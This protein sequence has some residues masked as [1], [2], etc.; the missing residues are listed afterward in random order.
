MR[1]C[2]VTLHARGATCAARHARPFFPNRSE[3]PPAPTLMHSD[4]SPELMPQMRANMSAEEELLV[5]TNHLVE[6]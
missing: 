4:G 2:C 5:Q 3:R 1:P 6:Q